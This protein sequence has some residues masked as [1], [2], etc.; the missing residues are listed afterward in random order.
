M[1]R[2]IL[3]SIFLISLI[4]VRGQISITAD[5][6]VISKLNDSKDKFIPTNRQSESLSLEIDKDLLTLR[7]FG[8]DHE[9]AVIEKGY[10]IELLEVDDNKEK[11]EFQGED[12]NCIA[13]NITLDVNRKRINF[14]TSGKEPAIEEPLTMI[15]YPIVDIKINKEAIDKHLKERGNT[16]Y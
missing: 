7:V 16:K 3:I 5:S 11:W 8:K 12:K 14:I 1:K 13:Y 15:S 4:S 6:V 9:H 2:T 10:I